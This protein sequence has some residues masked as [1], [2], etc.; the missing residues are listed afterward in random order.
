MTGAFRA[1]VLA[2]IG[3]VAAV[4]PGAAASEAFEAR[5]VI[6]SGGLVGGE[7][8]EAV[9][10]FATTSGRFDLGLAFTPKG[11][12][13][14]LGVGPAQAASAGE[15]GS[16]RLA[17][18]Q[19]SLSYS[20]R[21]LAERRRIGFAGGQVGAVE[22]V[23]DKPGGF[24]RGPRVL[25]Y[26]PRGLPALEPIAPA[27]MRNVLDPL[28]AIVLPA[29]AASPGARECDRRLRVYDGQRRFDLIFSP[30]G[31]ESGIDGAAIPTC[32]VRFAPL[33][34]QSRDGDEFTPWMAQAVIAVALT[35]S[36]GGGWLV[37]ARI[38]FE[39]GGTRGEARLVS[40]SAR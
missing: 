12:A 4:A 5:Y 7:M 24:N 37:P 26:D 23:K 40:L 29:S 20:V 27:Q 25:S 13:R 16:G 1:A 10:R 33:G 34:G 30:Q 21:A 17:P 35:S 22:I 9:M 15:A 32:R 8:G 28:A 38:A 31:K 18:A 3:F 11:V 14:A 2:G 19:A 36:P 39:S 6:R